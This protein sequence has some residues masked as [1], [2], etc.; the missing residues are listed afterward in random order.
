MRTTS[1]FGLKKPDYTDFADIADINEN[2]DT[3]DAELAAPTGDVKDATVS[4]ITAA[5]ASY[6]VPSA[7]EKI[8]V[9]LGKINKFFSDLKGDTDTLKDAVHMDSTYGNVGCPINIDRIQKITGYIYKVNP[10]GT[11]FTGTW[12]TDLL[13]SGT[14]MLIG[15]SQMH[16]TAGT[17]TYGFQL[18]FSHS[19][20]RIAYRRV[21]SASGAEWN[22]W[23]YVSDEVA[24]TTA[25][26]LLPSLSGSTKHF[27][28]GNNAWKLTDI[29]LDQTYGSES[30]PINIDTVTNINGYIYKINPSGSDFSGTAPSEV[31]GSAI[32]IGY[33]NSSLSAGR[34]IIISHQNNRIWTRRPSGNVWQAWEYISNELA[35]LSAKGM[36][37]ALS[38]NTSQYLRGDGTWQS[39]Q[40]NATT[41]SAGYGLDARMGKTLSDKMN[42][43]LAVATFT[44]TNQTVNAG[45]TKTITISNTYRS[46]YSRFYHRI[47]FG[48]TAA[49]F[50]LV[51]QEG[52]VSEGGADSQIV[53]RN[54]N[55]S[56]AFSGTITVRVYYWH[57][58][59]E[60]IT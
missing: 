15:Y 43:M 23:Q 52:A 24:T 11:E 42:G 45:A 49:T 16:S 20:R 12:P 53:V 22:S 48:G 2:M 1:N 39:L 18:A 35:T 46:G 17:P 51:T 8:R 27:L 41:T 3:I 6:P 59:I 4:A 56:T 58:S 38:G 10:A 33:S 37:R 60:D 40:N 9:I 26:G 7:G 57:G 25:N 36:L 28:T 54:L 31:A 19:S 13:G 14:G 32:L 50:M 34:Q 55:T 29:N 44:L 5:S 47:L 21:A 30:A